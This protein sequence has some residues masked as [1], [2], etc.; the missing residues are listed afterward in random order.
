MRVDTRSSPATAA[1]GAPAHRQGRLMPIIVAHGL[2][3]LF[4]TAPTLVFA[5]LAMNGAL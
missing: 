2:V 3:N 5:L 4:M 1:G